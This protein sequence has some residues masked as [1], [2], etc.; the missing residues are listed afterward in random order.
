M[1]KGTELF[2]YKGERYTV[3]GTGNHSETLE[4]MLVYQKDD[5]KQILISPLNMISDE[6]EYNGEKLSRFEKVP[7]G[8]YGGERFLIKDLEV[9]TKFFV[10]N[11]VWNG[12]IVLKDGEKCILL[13]DD[14]FENA[15]SFT[16]DYT[17]ELTIK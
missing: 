7:Y 14:K 9:G 15:S 3:L 12:Q 16:D 6:V 13:E 10:H 5:D 2:D 4:E 17:L 1:E 11:G 8:P